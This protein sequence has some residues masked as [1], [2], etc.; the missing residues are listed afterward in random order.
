MEKISLGEDV[1]EE[2][3]KMGDTEQHTEHQSVEEGQ[4]EPLDDNNKDKSSKL[5]ELLAA[6]N[7][8]DV[9]AKPIKGE[10]RRYKNTPGEAFLEEF[11][12]QDCIYHST[13]G[14]WWS[15][16]ICLNRY[17]RQFRWGQDKIPKQ[18]AIIGI[19][20]SDFDWDKE[21]NEALD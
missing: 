10:L 16:E 19:F 13:N 7:K 21:P 2:D 18:I 1:E 20:D 12:R 4:A 8:I 14:D 11:P 17:I 9:I 5:T 3:E 15:Y 6:I